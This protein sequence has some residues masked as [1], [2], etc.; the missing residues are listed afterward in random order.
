VHFTMNPY[1]A[2]AGKGNI[3]AKPL[4]AF[5]AIQNV[6][7][8]A[9][10]TM[11]DVEY[12][13]PFLTGN[14][15]DYPFDAYRA[16]SLIMFQE[17]NTTNPVP[18][19]FLFDGV[20]AGVNF[21]SDFIEVDGG[22]PNMYDFVAEV[23]RN[24][25]TLFFSIFVVVTMWLISIAIFIMAV[26]VLFSGREIPPPLVG[27]GATILFAFPALRNSF[28][29]VPQIGCYIDTV[30]FFGPISIVSIST[31]AIVFTFL[32]RWR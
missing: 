10:A 23:H 2:Y 3:L 32:L 18:V 11:Q 28:P 8:P 9:N 29:G 5:L 21:K 26:Q 31:C 14:V 13:V 16:D 12:N 4:T 15:R 22:T 27:F 25:T 19:S 20:I 1:G 7:F 6:Q 30:G 17:T 24:S